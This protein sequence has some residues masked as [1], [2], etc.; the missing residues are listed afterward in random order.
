MIQKGSWEQTGL[1]LGLVPE[2]PYLILPN[3]PEGWSQRVFKEML[4]SGSGYST[5]YRQDGQLCM[6]LRY[7]RILGQKNCPHQCSQITKHL[8]VIHQHFNDIFFGSFWNESQAIL[9]RVFDES[10]TIIGRQFLKKHRKQ[11]IKQMLLVLKVT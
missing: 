5:A 2:A 11:E 10:I 9:S 4:N 6:V 1:E 7:S 3:L 8:V